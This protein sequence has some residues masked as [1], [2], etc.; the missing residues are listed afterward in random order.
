V[1]EVPNIHLPKSPIVSIPILPTRQRIIPFEEKPPKP[2]LLR[3]HFDLNASKWNIKNP[4][5]KRSK[6]LT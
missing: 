1:W 4:V 2:P 6:T 5:P 3:L